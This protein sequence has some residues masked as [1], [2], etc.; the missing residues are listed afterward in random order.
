MFSII[1]PLY[2]KSPFIQR[3]ID[4]VLNQSFK[5]YEV[6]VVNDGS[7]DGGGEL[8]AKLYGD[9]VNLINQTNQGVSVARNTGISKAKF[10]YI[11]FLDADD[12]WH[13]QYLEFVA[14]VINE[15]PKVSII[16]THYDSH[17]LAEYPI[18]N[19][20]TLQNYF[21]QAARNTRFFTSATVLY[22]SFFHHQEG[23]D[24]TLSLGEDIDVWLRASLF[25]GDGIYIQNTL[26]YYGQDDGFQATQRP[27]PI[28][29]SLISK[30]L[31]PD[32]YSK[33][34]KNSTCIKKEFDNFKYQW[35]LLSLYPFFSNPDNKNQIKKI[36]D[37]I[38]N[39]FFP[40]LIWYKFPFKLLKSHFNKPWAIKIFRNYMKFCF[41]LIYT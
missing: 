9:K 38:P 17:M 22:R 27:H 2:N 26:V 13:P 1:I 28:A 6:I 11:A 37:Q 5:D 7:T 4:S 20:F 40:V 8:V 35:V 31:K 10:D 19:Y 34:I 16:G 18:L 32:Y 36:L 14:Q 41:R 25:F 30:I 24:P 29:N 39:K 12:Y 15:N 23:F 21:N 33:A 3:A